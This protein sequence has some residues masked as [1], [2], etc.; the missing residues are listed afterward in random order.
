MTLKNIV[1]DVAPGHSIPRNH[2][3]DRRSD[4]VFDL[5]NRTGTNATNGTDVRTPSY[6]PFG[7]IGNGAKGYK[8]AFVFAVLSATGRV[9]G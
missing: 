5:T 4:D 6:V 9:S 2:A 8:K 1:S 3:Q 7:Y